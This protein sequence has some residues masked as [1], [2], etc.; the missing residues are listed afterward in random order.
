[1][2]NEL[3]Y[4]ERQLVELAAIGGSE[5][6]RTLALVVANSRSSFTVSYVR[7]Q[8]PTYCV[9]TLAELRAVSTQY[10]NDTYSADSE[11]GPAAA[12]M[13]AIDLTELPLQDTA[14]FAANLRFATKLGILYILSPKQFD[15]FEEGTFDCVVR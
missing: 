4:R 6:I 15:L 2:S 13:I 7:E 14:L 9:A 12:H 11:Q 5:H 10:F 8:V 1:M 3:G